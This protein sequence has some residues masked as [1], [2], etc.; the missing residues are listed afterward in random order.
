MRIY[1]FHAVLTLFC[2]YIFFSNI[3]KKLSTFLVLK[4]KKIIESKVVDTVTRKYLSY[5]TP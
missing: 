5:V 2:I 4:K 3:F 1:T